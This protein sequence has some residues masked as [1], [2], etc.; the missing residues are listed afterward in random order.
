MM[1]KITG[2]DYH[3]LDFNTT[4]VRLDDI[5]RFLQTD[6]YNHFNTTVVR[7]DAKIVS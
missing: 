5:E 4:V 7:L 2:K 1:N 3:I 6:E